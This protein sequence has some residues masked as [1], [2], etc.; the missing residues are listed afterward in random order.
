[1]AR[2]VLPALLAFLLGCAGPS[3]VGSTKEGFPIVRIPLR[4]SSVYLIEAKRPVL[5]DSG[6]VGDM[7]DL[8]QA[9]KDQGVW[10]SQAA[11][12]VLTHGHAD[13]A[14]LAADIRAKSGAEIWLGEGDLPLARAGHSG[15][16]AATGAVAQGLKPFITTVYEDFE[17]DVAVR[18]PMSLAPYGIDGEVLPMPG[19]TKGSLV[20]VLGNQTAFVGDMMMGGLGGLVFA[21]RPAE[22]L[23]EA[24]REA[25]RKNIERL[26]KRGVVTFYLGHGGPLRRE[27][28][29]K[30]FGILER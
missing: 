25:N 26:V 9:L 13:H 23:Y 14:G 2:W 28:V 30:A 11:L 19:H 15:D 4:L 1:V 29:I 7:A 24:D 3:V 10:L 18:A 6:T 8:D 27:D 5:I 22:H 21:D 20:V 17:P 12:V 16:L